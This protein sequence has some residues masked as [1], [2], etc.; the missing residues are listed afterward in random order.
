MRYFEQKFKD[1]SGLNWA[2]RLDPP[3]KG[4]YT[5]IERRYEGDSSDDEGISGAGSQK[6][7][8]PQGSDTI[9]PRIK[10]ES[11]L[12]KSVQ[13]L[14]QLIF[15]Q[16]Y[17][18]DTM[19][20][21]DYDADKLPLGQLSKRTLRLGFEALK[22]VGELLADPSLAQDKFNMT[23]QQAIEETSN[24]FYT[25]IPH[26]FGFRRPPVIADEN[27]LQKEITLLESL[28]D[29]EIASKIM[30]DTGSDDGIHALDRQFAGLGLQETE[31]L[32]DMSDEYKQLE[33]YLVKS[34]G[35]TQSSVQGMQF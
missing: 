14:M 22:E 26:N 3:K 4:K 8:K 28:S 29:M 11:T 18:A 27:R 23:Y 31:P 12:P 21:M 20:E 7:S 13:Q 25:L 19:R 32:E 30:K 9:T 5:F 24:S 34:H 17:F 10:A 33:E 35:S 16:Q 1:K 6:N 15:N 2:S